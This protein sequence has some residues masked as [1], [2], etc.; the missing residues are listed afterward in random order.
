MW[1]QTGKSIG[2]SIAVANAQLKSR[3]FH[4]ITSP[5]TLSTSNVIRRNQHSTGGG[6]GGGGR[7]ATSSSVVSA[8]L[9]VPVIPNGK[10]LNNIV[11]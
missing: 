6:G 7:D 11:S 5:S 8:T 3:S 2:S 1:R 10:Q 4:R 9:S